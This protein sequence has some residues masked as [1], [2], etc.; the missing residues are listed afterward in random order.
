MSSQRGNALKRKPQKHKNSVAFKND[1]HDTSNRTKQINS[2]EHYGVCIRCKD[3]IEWKVKYKKYKPLTKPKKCV[4]CLNPKVLTAY[5]IV[6]QGCCESLKVCSKCSK[7]SDEIEFGENEKEQKKKEIEFQQEIKLLSE[8]KRRKF[9]R[10]LEKGELTKENLKENLKNG[11]LDSDD[12]DSDYEEDE[13]DDD[14]KEDSDVALNKVEKK[15]NKV[16]FEDEDEGEDSSDEEYPNSD[17]DYANEYEEEL[18]EE[19]AI[20]FKK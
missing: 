10:L 18:A 1:L 19:E 5:Y 12:N 17:D 7:P 9:L 2:L 15:L 8:R 3:I 20:A 4:K 16:S 11:D 14:D 13:E 6:C